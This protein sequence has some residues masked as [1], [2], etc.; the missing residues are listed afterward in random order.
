MTQALPT[1]RDE[2]WRYSD[3]RALK[4]AVALPA[5]PRIPSP[6]APLA[7]GPNL[8]DAAVADAPAAL[9]LVT[10][11]QRHGASAEPQLL[12]PGL[13]TLAID[14]PAG[15]AVHA[16]QT[17]RVPAG[18]TATLIEPLSGAGWLN[19]VRDIVLEP[20]ARLHHVLRQEC[21]ADATLTVTLGVDLAAGAHYQAFV[22]NA[23]AHFARVELRAALTGAGAHVAI[24]GVQLGD[25]RQ[26]LEIIT[27]LDHRAAGTTGRQAV[28]SVLGGQ[29]TGSYLG[30]VR[31]APG[32]QQTDSEQ[33]AKALLLKRTATVNTK[34]ELE[35]HA[36]DVKC[37]HGATVG[38]LDKA[39]LFY[40]ES[41][42][43][44]PAEARML[45]T[46]AFVA[47][48]VETIADAATRS[49]IAARTT[50]RLQA[51]LGGAPA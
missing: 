33:S 26:T 36:D 9:A 49:D 4:A 12:G 40:L 11:A 20:G 24:D 8:L 47:D 50:A 16:R 17:L 14:A 42:G 23:G 22:L 28:K 37:A 3:L 15:Q 31:V 27:A 34:P 30:K 48:L 2:T 41:R 51:M 18:V 1:T 29:A 39:A 25:Q 38:E 19:L 13:I 35:I 5:T 45:L 44:S 6:A 21:D 10:L 43:L 7:A 32:A 46:E